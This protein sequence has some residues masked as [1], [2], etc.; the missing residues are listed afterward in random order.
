[1]A[2]IKKLGMD[3]NAAGLQLESPQH[4]LYIEAQF[5]EG[6]RKDSI[7]RWEAA[8]TALTYNPSTA[9]DYWTLGIRMLANDNQP[10]RAQDATE[11]LINGLEGESDPRVLIPIIRSWLSSGDS[12]AVQRAW[13]LYVRLKFLL[14]SKIEMKDYD[15]IIGNFLEAQQDDLALRIFT[16]M[17]ITGDPC[18]YHQDSIAVYKRILKEV[19]DLR[20]FN[21]STVEVSWTSHE[22]FTRLPRRYRNK[23]FFGSWIKKL[24]GDGEVDAAARVANLMSR[25]GIIPDSKYMNGIVGAWFRSGSSLNYQKAEELAWKMID[26]RLEFVQSREQFALESPLRA[27]GSLEKPD[28]I[29]L[30]NPRIFSLATI[31]TFCILVNYYL[32][33]R[34]GDRVQDICLAI[35]AAKIQPN[36]A[37]LNDLLSIGTIQ[38]RRQWVWNAY[39]QLV[40]R[41]NVSPDHD[42]FANLWQ[43]MKEHVNPRS[44]KSVGFPLPRELF[45]EMVKWPPSAKR[46]VI[47]REIY[48]MI[49]ECFLITD[50]QVGTAV[51]LRAMQYL[52][53]IYPT[54]DTSQNII[55]QLAASG[56]RHTLKPLPRTLDRGRDT[57]SRAAKLIAALRDLKEKRAAA[58]RKKGVEFDDIDDA[59]KS[60]ELVLLLCGLLQ[61]A[62]NSTIVHPNTQGYIDGL[63]EEHSSIPR[64]IELAAK[65]MGVFQC[66]PLLLPNSTN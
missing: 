66:V 11:T 59:S 39:I 63:A 36:T 9:R 13:A 14:G 49:I 61:F 12:S 18:A 50:D 47:S 20:S 42:T 8:R 60:E 46:G 17:M 65:E 53:S 16:D 32:R 41:E 10:E 21:L 29:Q 57:Q 2:H 15:A 40:Q 4:L 34:R 1:M 37:F 19:G 30:I 44:R 27:I 43:I 5:V 55:L 35:K 38:N 58:L 45:A 6:D 62:T 56:T 3:M 52:F 24:I 26:A 22:P 64:L 28:F 48:E 33:R 31:E 54:K 51:A 7:R 25:R 23:Y